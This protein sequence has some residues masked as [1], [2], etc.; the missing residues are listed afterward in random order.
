MCSS[1]APVCTGLKGGCSPGLGS[2][3]PDGHCIPCDGDTQPASHV[4]KH[5]LCPCQMN[6]PC[7]QLCLFPLRELPQGRPSVA[8]A[9]EAGQL[10]LP[11]LCSPLV[12]WS[13]SLLFLGGICARFLWRQAAALYP[14][15]EQATG[16]FPPTSMAELQLS[17]PEASSPSQ[18]VS[19]TNP[20]GS[21]ALTHLFAS[22]ISVCWAHP[23]CPPLSQ[24]GT[25][26]IGGEEVTLEYTLCPEFWRCK[27]VSMQP[28]SCTVLPLLVFMAVAAERALNFCSM[29][30]NPQE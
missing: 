27:R 29:A 7:S 21:R 1:P 26:T 16:S 11:C 28:E 9:E 24:Q 6:P 13:L 23:S 25:L 3:S 20:L 4:P 14:T 17:E 2:G 19:L 22:V 8:G 5:R 30:E 12:P 10:P 15:L 18:P